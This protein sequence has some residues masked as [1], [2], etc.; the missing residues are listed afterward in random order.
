MEA[1]LY[2]QTMNST[3]SSSVGFCSRGSVGQFVSAILMALTVAGAILLERRAKFLSTPA[4][5]LIL[6]V[7]LVFSAVYIHYVLRDMRRLDELQRRIHLEAAAVGCLGTF[8]VMLLYPAVQ[9]AGF[10]GQLSP[11]NVVFVLFGCAGLGYVNAVRRY[12]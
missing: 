10:L 7:P 8:M 3:P 6:L 4:K 12:Q 9:Y 2:Y 1:L 11:V 5:A